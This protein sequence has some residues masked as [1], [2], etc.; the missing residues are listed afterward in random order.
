MLDGY[1]T[2]IAAGLL[3]LVS[4]LYNFGYIDFQTFTAVG[5]ALG[6]TGLSFLRLGMEGK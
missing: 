6:G 3:I 1:K 4:I 2:H 5:A